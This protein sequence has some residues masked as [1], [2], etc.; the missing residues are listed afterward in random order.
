MAKAAAI[1]VLLLSAA[2]AADKYTE[3][4]GLA[5]VPRYEV[6]STDEEIRID[7][8]LEEKS[9]SRAEAIPLIFPWEFQTGKKQE[10]SVKLL[11]GRTDL[12]VGYECRDTDVTASYENRDDPVYRDDCVEI[13]IRPD[14]SVDSYV[15]LEMNARGIL[16]DYYYPFPNPLD[17]SLTLDGVRLMTE[18]RGTLNRREDQDQGWTLELA[19]PFNSLSKVAKGLP[20]RSGDRWR[21][22]INRWDGVE[23]SGG[24]RL[25]M[26]THS[27]LRRAHP[28]NPER[29]GIVIF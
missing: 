15:G 7:G 5:P 25:S 12:F 14:E 4:P 17:K 28:H 19:I 29:F 9:W 24:R 22:Q 2:L 21:I 10:T 1:I 27:G 23:D 20:P 11:R 16:Y 26:W 8:K 13:F 18:I 6:R 3:I